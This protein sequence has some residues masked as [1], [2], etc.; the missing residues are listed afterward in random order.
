MSSKI[1]YKCFIYLFN[2]SNILC[3]KNDANENLKLSKLLS[4]KNLLFVPLTFFVR[5]W[6]PSSVEKA[7]FN[8]DAYVPTGLSF[9]FYY[10]FL[11]MMAI[12]IF[13]FAACI[14]I[15][16]WNREKNLKLILQCVNIF[17]NYELFS[18]QS[19]KNAE[20]KL[21]VRTFA[22]LTL[23]VVL[24]CFEYSGIALL[25]WEGLLLYML[26]P[27][28][29]LIGLI[30]LGFFNCFLS[31]FEFLLDFLSIELEKQKLRVYKRFNS[32]SVVNFAVD[33]HSLI[34]E[35]EKTLGNL[36]TLAVVLI[37]ITSTI[38]VNFCHNL[39]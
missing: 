36:L 15:Q 25:N 12:N 31:Y 4:W 7:G 21:F 6:I 35:F 14:Y 32:E 30:L 27:N 33:L 37:V 3:L 8:A 13:L 26:Y 19:F 24:I 22:F 17:Q 16:W 20:K 9:F 10:S 1:F 23:L 11:I 39:N 29:G 28:N 2:L 5:F 34:V 38:R 18:E